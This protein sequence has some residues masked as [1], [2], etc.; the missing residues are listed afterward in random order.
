MT[1]PIRELVDYCET[2]SINL[3][4]FL[5][6]QAQA[7]D[8]L[9]KVYDIL[10][11]AYGLATRFPPWLAGVIAQ[12]DD[13]RIQCLLAKQLNGELGDGDPSRTHLVLY[14][15]AIGLLEPFQPAL[16]VDEATTPGQ[17]FVQNAE[18]YFCSTDPYEAL[19]AVMAGEVYGSQFFAWLGEALA[20]QSRVDTYSLD[21]FGAHETLE[22]EHAGDSAVIGEFLDDE[23]ARRESIWRGALGIDWAIK[24]FLDDLHRRYAAARP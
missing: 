3:H 2:H 21:W 6:W 23:P 7:A 4:P 8:P 16:P 13:Q 12:L 22:I 18:R 15:R 5:S 9:T 1:P 11:N 14:Q 17:R 19:G 10:A 20:R 24:S